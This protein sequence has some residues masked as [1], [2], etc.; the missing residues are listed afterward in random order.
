M[1]SHKYSIAGN[2]ITLVVLET[3]EKVNKS[4]FINW[5]EKICLKDKTV[6]GVAFI[7]KS[8]FQY[9]FFNS[10]GSEEMI[11]GNSLF[12]IGYYFMTTQ[13]VI[14]IKKSDIFCDINHSS[15]DVILRMKYPTDKL[16]R[17]YPIFDVGTPHFV[18]QVEDISKIYWKEYKKS[19]NLNTTLYSINH[20]EA[21]GRTF[22]RGVNKE[23]LACGTGA[24]SI[25][26]HS[27]KEGINI[28]KVIYY[29]SK[30]CYFLN[31]IEFNN[32]DVTIEVRLPN[33]NISIL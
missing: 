19:E 33:T 7:A 14:K 4:N 21:L 3:L 13:R 32:S 5:I 15:K 6:E 28:Q 26:I 11:C 29:N 1:N 2:V 23:T 30:C 31:S 9:Y 24:I 17:Q 20:D 12:A 8:N 25:F 10:D 18:S 16:F 22:E 27:Q